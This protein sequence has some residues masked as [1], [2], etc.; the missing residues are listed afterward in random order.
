M[1]T[2]NNLKCHMFI[3]NNKYINLN[4]CIDLYNF[5]GDLCQDLIKDDEIINIKIIYNDNSV[6][7]ININ[8]DIDIL[9]FITKCI[10]ISSNIN[11]LY[12]DQSENI[13]QIF[14]DDSLSI[15]F[16]NQNNKFINDSCKIKC[17][18]NEEFD[19][20]EYN[21]IIKY[22]KENINDI[23]RCYIIYEYPSDLII[24][25]DE[26]EINEDND[27]DVIDKDYTTMTSL[28]YDNNDNIKYSLTYMYYE[29]TYNHK[30]SNNNLSPIEQFINYIIEH[31]KIYE[32]KINSYLCPSFID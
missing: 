7:N 20:I 6:T 28:V 15:C 13:N 4:Q 31:T 30:L 9:E 12:F 32:N 11:K 22:V 1:N 2:T 23:V 17:L 25:S 3:Y 29:N 16:I 10:L 8:N 19:Y 18:N 27:V 21:N 5:E 24:S 14:S 26:D